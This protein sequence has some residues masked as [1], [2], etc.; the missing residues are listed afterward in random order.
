VITAAN[1]QH[2]QGAG[3]LMWNLPRACRKMRLVWA[4]AGYATSKLTAWAATMKTAIQVVAKRDRH[5][6]E[7]LL[8]AGLSG[9]PPPGSAS[10]VHRPRLRKAARQ[11]EAMITWDIALMTRL[12]Y[13]AGPIIRRSLTAD[14][15]ADNHLRQFF[16]RGG[17]PPGRCRAPVVR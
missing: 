5:V 3:P 11:P 13:P 4:D 15:R 17:F 1:V 8:A 14:T 12:A 10:T 6:F 9:G 16:G 7:V 2:R